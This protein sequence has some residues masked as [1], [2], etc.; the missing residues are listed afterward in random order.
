MRKILVLICLVSVFGCGKKDD[1]KPPEQVSLLFPE[2]NSECTTGVDQDANTSRVTFM[3]Q[4]SDNTDSYELRVTNLNT[5]TVQTISTSSTTSSLPLLKGQPYTWLVRSRNDQVRNT[6]SSEMWSFYN[7]GS[8]TTFAPFPAEILTP[9]MS[10]KVF[11][12]INNDITLSW[13][14][15]DLDDDIESIEIYFSEQNPPSQ[16]EATLSGSASS[17]K[18]SVTSGTMYHWSVITIDAEGNATSSGVYTFSVL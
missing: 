6:V 18:V 8:R 16:L 3:W 9:K 7:A 12:D 15:A 2:R 4:K 13:S 17:L 14:A 1:P 11:K 5:S 10:E